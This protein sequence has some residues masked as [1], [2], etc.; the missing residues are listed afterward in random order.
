MRIH[1]PQPFLS[2]FPILSVIP[3]NSKLSM[4]L[5]NLVSNM[6]C[7]N[8]YFY[9]NP[10]GVSRGSSDRRGFDEHVLPSLYKMAAAVYAVRGD[11][12]RRL[13]LLRGASI[14]VLTRSRRLGNK[15]GC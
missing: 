13:E 10:L 9:V 4:I 7:S 11:E 3:F 12:G 5:S 1:V 2:Y 8:T 14:H 15:W 6:K